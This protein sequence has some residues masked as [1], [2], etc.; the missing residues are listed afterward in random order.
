MPDQ[1]AP[2]GSQP[3]P[4]QPQRRPGILHCGGEHHAAAAS[5]WPPGQQRI[6]VFGPED[7]PAVGLGDCLD[8]AQQR[9]QIRRLEV[10]E[11][12]LGFDRLGRDQ[13]LDDAHLAGS[14]GFH[15]KYPRQAGR[16]PAVV[17]LP[18][19]A[20]GD[21]LQ[22]L[23]GGLLAYGHRR[24]RD[25]GGGDLF[26][27][28][29]EVAWVREA[30]AEHDHVFPIG[31]RLVQRK[32]GLFHGRVEV[33]AAAGRDRV[34][35]LEHRPLVG[36]GLDGADPAAVVFK[37]D[38]AHLI[39]RGELF[40][41]QPGGLPGQFDALALHRFGAVDHQHHGQA[42]LGPIFADLAPHG[43]DLFQHGLAVA[44]RGQRPVAAD[45]NQPAA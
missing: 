18:L 31:K 10:W 22:Q 14:G 44:T 26:G 28:R 27:Q 20:A 16:V 41:R 9:R 37:R 8:V 30:V 29:L 40:D 19:A 42:R 3:G 7:K 6:A 25:P 24:D 17:V 43:E 15:R 12:L 39:A 45:H 32:V 33:G 1:S 23:P 36:A 2:E 34:D 35:P 11:N 5:A 38:H 21:V 4:L 13:F